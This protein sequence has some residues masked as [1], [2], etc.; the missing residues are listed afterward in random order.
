MIFILFL[1]SSTDNAL[2]DVLLRYRKEVIKNK[3]KTY[4]VSEL[5][6]VLYIYMDIIFILFYTY[7]GFPRICL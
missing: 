7:M 5:F 3:R 6:Y 2:V 4:K 1:A